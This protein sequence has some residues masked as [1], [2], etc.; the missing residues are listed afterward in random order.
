MSRSISWGS[1][2]G[3]DTVRLAIKARY[4]ISVEVH[5]QPK[6]NIRSTRTWETGVSSNTTT[7]I[8]MVGK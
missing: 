5:N 1:D 8:R 4:K 3:D 7:C 2:P 6:R